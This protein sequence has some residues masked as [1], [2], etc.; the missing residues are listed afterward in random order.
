ISPGWENETT[1][2]S[3]MAYP[4]FLEIG[5]LNIARI[6]RL[7]ITPSPRFGYSS[8]AE[9]GNPLT[10]LIAKEG[11]RV[12]A[13]MLPILTTNP[14]D[15]DAT[16]RALYGAWLSGSTLATVTLGLHHKLCHAL[17]GGFGLPHAE[18]HAVILPH[19]T[20]FNAAAARQAVKRVARAL[21]TEG[22]AAGLYDLAH[23]IGAPTSLADLGM[24]EEDLDRAADLAVTNPYS[25]PRPVERE[26][27]RKLLAD[28]F[29]GRR[30]A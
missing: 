6:R 13:A 23:R 7:Y 10:S 20:A 19:A 27:V 24:R 8:Y 17:G 28:A 16:G 21:G 3:Y 2:S 22:A 12:L 26:S 14:N 5:D 4:S 29:H 25:N 9:D 15:R 11:I 18:T 1:L 30:P